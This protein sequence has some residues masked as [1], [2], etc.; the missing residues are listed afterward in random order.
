M[1]SLRKSLFPIISL[2]LVASVAFAQSSKELL[3]R[4]ADGKH[5]SAARA[6]AEFGTLAGVDQSSGLLRLKLNTGL[7]LRAVR[8]NL[9]LKKMMLIAVPGDHDKVDR[10]SYDSVSDQVTYLTEVE[11]HAAGSHKGLEKGSKN[12]TAD[13]LRAHQYWLKDRIDQTGTVNYQ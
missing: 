3:I 9:L 4:T 5:S 12:E 1:L 10:R 7:N 13:A 2:C 11:R 6:T 8:R